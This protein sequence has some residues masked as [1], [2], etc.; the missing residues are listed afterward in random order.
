MRARVLVLAVTAAFPLG[1]GEN[2][3]T[4]GRAFTPDDL[5]RLVRGA[6]D[7]PRL[8]DVRVD[9]R[10]LQPNDLADG[11]GIAQDIGLTPAELRRVGVRGARQA[12]LF[13]GDESENAEELVLLVEDPSHAGEALK[14]L[15]ARLR[16]ELHTEAD[17]DAAELRTID[18]GG[19]G[20]EAIAYAQQNGAIVEGTIYIWRDRNVVF[21][22]WSS[23]AWGDPVATGLAERAAAID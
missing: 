23:P 6:D 19:L 1:C 9:M 3:T 22:V 10:T 5:P 2:E 8:K 13:R 11:L 12:V 14:V 21:L 18:S 15:R 20:D 17:D 4:P 7:A 16:A